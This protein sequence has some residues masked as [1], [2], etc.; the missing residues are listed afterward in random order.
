MQPFKFGHASHAHW[1]EAAYVCLKQIE[2]VSYEDNLGFLYVTDLLAGELSAILD[3]FKQ[4]TEVAH[5]VG[6]VGIGICSQGKEYLDEPAIAVMLG[7]FPPHAFE[8]FTTAN[9]DFEAFSRTHQAWCEVKKPMFAIV[10]GDPRHAEM[11]NLVFQLSERLGEGFLVGGLTSSRGA[12]LQI[13][14]EI[15]PDG[16]SGVMFASDVSVA[17]RLT[18]GCA[19]ISAR[20][21]ITAAQNNILIEI[22]NRPALEVFYEDIGEVLARDLNKIAGYIFAALPVPGSDTGDYLVRNLL[23]I[24]PEHELI[25][26]SENVQTGNSIMF[27][28]R[29]PQ[30]AYEDLVRVLKTLKKDVK[31]PLKGGVYFSCLG[32][33]KNMFG[34]DSQ[35]LKAIQ[36][37]LGDFPLVGFFASGEISHQRLYGYTGV[38]T[39]FL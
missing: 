7:N 25:A 28:R 34:Q 31:E 22:D 27:A 5:W 1:Q 29:D 3:F 19:L 23:G 36:S 35:E 37:V 10:H 2:P 11:A 32:R 8:V 6:T 30:T 39:L 33:G 38:L 20:H 14:D 16:L 21:Q 4:H 13:A 15:V 17:T 12:Y 26:I 9:T 18:Q 24:D